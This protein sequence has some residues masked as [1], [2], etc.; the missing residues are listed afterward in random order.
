L[1]Q[2]ATTVDG[3]AIIEFLAKR[4]AAYPDQRTMHIIW[5]NAAY[6]KAQVVKEK[7]QA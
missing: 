2:Q 3:A 7:A 5:D 4:R 6:H 1:Y